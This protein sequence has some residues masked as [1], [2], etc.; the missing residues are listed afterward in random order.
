VYFHESYFV[1]GHFHLMI[2]VVTFLATFAGVYY[3]F[4]KMFG[5]MMNERLGQIHFWLTAAPM[6]VMFVLMHFQGMG[7]ALRRMYDHNAYEY[8][9]GVRSLHLPISILGFIT[10]GSQVI[11]LWNFFWSA[12]RGRK[13]EPN[14]WQSA[15]LEWSGPAPA[16]HGNW[17]RELPNVHRWPYDYTPN[18]QTPD[19]VPQIDPAPKA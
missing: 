6:Y 18:G 14:P 8:V 3:W 9:A 10:A 5:R 7:G 16:P 19:F 4:P 1:V 2:G 15:G 13:A 17:G 11:F 12:C